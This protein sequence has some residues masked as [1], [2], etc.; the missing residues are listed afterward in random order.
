MCCEPSLCWKEKRGRGAGNGA[1]LDDCSKQGR[2]RHCNWEP[3]MFTVKLSNI[4]GDKLRNEISLVNYSCVMNSVLLPFEWYW[5]A[6]SFG[7][8]IK[9]L[10]V[11]QLVTETVHVL[12]LFI[13]KPSQAYNNSGA[14]W[15][16]S[17]KMSWIWIIFIQLIICVLFWNYY[18]S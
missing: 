7:S 14:F 18:G 2:W 11:L 17:S 13:N 10:F 4:L 3:A 8:S 12:F 1:T 15:N 16:N 6:A 5:A 9:H